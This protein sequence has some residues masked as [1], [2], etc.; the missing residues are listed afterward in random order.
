MCSVTEEE[1]GLEVTFRRSTEGDFYFLI[2]FTEENIPLPKQFANQED[3][4]T[5]EIVTVE[6]VLKPYDVRIIKR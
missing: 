5:G 3:I 2:N 1:N 4:L 6:T